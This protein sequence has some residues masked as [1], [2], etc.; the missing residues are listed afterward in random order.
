MTSVLSVAVPLPLP[1]PLDYLAPDS[2]HGSADWLHCRVVVQVGPRELVGVVVDVAEQSGDTSRLR[3]IRARL[4]LSPLI[5]TEL[6]Q[7][8]R[9]AAQYYAHPL[10][11]VLQAALPVVL[12]R[13]DGKAE[14]LPA[15]ALTRAGTAAASVASKPTRARRVLVLLGAGPLTRVDLAAELGTAVTVLRQLERDGLVEAVDDVRRTVRLPLAGPPLN[16]EQQAACER[17]AAGLAPTRYDATLLE[18]VT[19]SGKTEVY[20]NLIAR[21]LATG[22]QALV[23]VPEIGLTPQAQKRYEERLGVRVAALHSGLAE[24]ERARSW[25]AAARGTA[26]VVLGTRSAVLTPLARAGLIVVDEEHD[27]SYKQQD[28]FRYHARDLALVRARALGIPVVLGSATPAL[29]TLA[30]VDAGRYQV[31][32]LSRR[33][34]AA[35]TPSVRLIDL[36]QQ[37]LQEGLSAP[38]VDAVAACVARGEQALVFR[39]RRGYAP[40]LLCHDCGWHADCPR[41]DAHLTLHRAGARLRCHHCGHAEPAPGTCPT[42]GSGSL[43]PLGAGTER[44]EEALAARIPGASVI[45][46]DSDTTRARGERESRWAAIESGAPA[47]LVGTQMLAKG[48]DLPNLTLAAL[49]DVDGGLFSADFRGAERLAQLVVQVAGR[50]GRGLKAGTVLLQTHHPE[51]P[52]LRR[53]LEG[54][55]AAFAREEL[56]QREMLG[57][58][59]YAHFALLRAEA[60]QREVVDAFLILA[61][62]AFSGAEGVM[63]RGP[64]P[65]PLPRR[66]GYVRGQLLV[67][68][69][70]RP[71]LQRAIAVAIEVLRARPESRRVRW[72]ID[73]DPVDLY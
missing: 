27:A 30:N 47:V 24:G 7:S 35:R 69:K 52:L 20:L 23:L 73:V 22:R 12:R 45:R 42:C 37:R 59:P 8:L 53:L 61:R 40:V 21:V 2:A 44:L 39:N 60:Q 68:S 49:V 55:Y 41:C 56:A 71:L 65:A 62:T 70:Q 51:H 46:M 1:G 10:G 15:Y 29:E 66:A 57:F 6:V 33:A 4:D 67:E 3:P 19:G 14:S 25:L 32:R 50:A 48:H 16:A 17:I 63:A 11:E 36:R 43:L 58:P 72:S 28:G 18:G 26:A 54:G 9:W 13:P 31:L 34:G 64:L 5:S 38:L